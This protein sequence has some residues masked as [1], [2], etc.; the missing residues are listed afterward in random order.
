ME[1]SHFSSI[2]SLDSVIRSMYH[3]YFHPKEA[4]IPHGILNRQITQSASKKSKTPLRLAVDI[5]LMYGF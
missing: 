1:I 5:T 3:K 2:Q 4:L